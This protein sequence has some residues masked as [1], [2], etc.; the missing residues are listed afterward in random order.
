MIDANIYNKCFHVVIKTVKIRMLAQ[1]IRNLMPMLH[2]KIFKSLST[3][4]RHL[5]GVLSISIVFVGAF[6]ESIIGT[7][8]LAWT[9][10]NRN[11]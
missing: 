3:D 7:E 11:Y 2:L 9:Y 1:I 6:I 8:L 5:K 10:I 4:Y